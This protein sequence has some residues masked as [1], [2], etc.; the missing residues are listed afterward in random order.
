[1]QNDS[2][3]TRTFH[4]SRLGE[5]RLEDVR[6]DERHNR[7]IARCHAQTQAVVQ[8]VPMPPCFQHKRHLLYSLN[9]Q[10][11]AASAG[12]LLLLHAK[13]VTSWLPCAKSTH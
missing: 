12:L 11:W 2:G 1:M 5:I 9:H 8:A 3:S 10:H 4:D 6:A 7:H 13:A